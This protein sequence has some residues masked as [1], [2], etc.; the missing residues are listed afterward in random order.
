VSVAAGEFGQWLAQ[1]QAALRGQ[2]GTDVPCGD[3]RGCCVSGYPIVLRK[4][5]AE[6]AQ[7]VSPQFLAQANGL[8]YM[9]ARDDGTCPML[10]DG[11]CSVY[12]QRPQTCRDYD[13]RVF[14]AGGVLPGGSQ[15]QVITQRVQAWRFD[16]ADEAAQQAHAAVQAAAAFI[17]RVAGTPVAPQWPRAPTGVAVLALKCWPLFLPDADAPATDAQLATDVAAAASQFD[18]GADT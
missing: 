4:G 17:T 16:Y 10:R 3:C 13:C 7:R 12:A 14:A 18:Q 2:G 11:N 5:D 6:V 15:R 8:Q 9:T 1:M